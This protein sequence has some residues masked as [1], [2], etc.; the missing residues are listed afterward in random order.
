MNRGAPFTF[1]KLKMSG[2]GG[3]DERSEGRFEPRG[4]DRESMISGRAELLLG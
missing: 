3:Q 2:S 1:D 4:M